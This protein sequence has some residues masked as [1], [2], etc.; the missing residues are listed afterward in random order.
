[1]YSEAK[2]KLA[3]TRRKILLSEFIATSLRIKFNKIKFHTSLKF[4]ARHVTN[5]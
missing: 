4:Y 3:E 1:M 2:E 5:P